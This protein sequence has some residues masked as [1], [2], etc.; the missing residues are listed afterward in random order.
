[1]PV[2][3]ITKP[4]VRSLDEAVML[5]LES[6]AE[7]NKKIAESD[8]KIAESDAKMAESKADLEKKIAESDAKM[9][10]SK[11]DLEKK[12]AESDAKIA[13]SQAKADRELR[14]SREKADREL[15]ES[16]EKTDRE[17]RE[18]R[19]KTDLAI[20]E[21]SNSLQK[22]IEEIREE[23]KGLSRRVDLVNSG[24]GSIGERFGKLVEFIVIPGI[25]PEMNKRGH[26]F[27]YATANKK[28][29]YM[30]AGKIE[31]TMEIDMFLHNGEKA[32]AV[33]VK[34]TLSTGDVDGHLEKLKKLRK[35]ETITNLKGKKLYGAMVAVFVDYHTQEYALKNGLY[36]VEILE[37]EQKLQVQAPKKARVW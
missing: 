1:M 26:N 10:E 34:T 20:R 16:R 17:L 13:E 28:F 7:S 24:L 18:S 19:E 3:T 36:I 21:L 2:E 22:T 35:Y 30:A 5:M 25:R 32:M 14:E 4:K 37:Q 6:I 31:K 33:E 9:A 15:R 27:R 11:A 12:I 23:I 29:K 8:A